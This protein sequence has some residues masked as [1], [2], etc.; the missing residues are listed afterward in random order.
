MN[1]QQRRASRFK[2]TQRNLY[3]SHQSTA[4]NHVA[5]AVVRARIAMEVQQLYTRAGVHLFI[6]EDAARVVDEVGRLVF[7]V[8]HAAGLHDLGDT[9]EAATLLAT[10][11]TLADLAATPDAL[12]QQRQ[13]LQTGLGAINRLLP[14]LHGHSLAAGAQELDRL[15]R[16][17]DL[18][19]SSVARALQPQAQPSWQLGQGAAA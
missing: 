13:A 14:H 10:G 6:G 15:L 8:A 18:T 16:R 11:Q 5:Q 12:E 7:I 9:P 17:G 2:H 3:E 1:R 19:T 4:T